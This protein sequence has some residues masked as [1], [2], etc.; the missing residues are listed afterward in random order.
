MYN[1]P[2][3]LRSAREIKTL[4]SHA[5]LIAKHQEED[6][7]VLKLC[8]RAFITWRYWPC[9]TPGSPEPISTLGACLALDVL[10]IGR[11]ALPTPSSIS[12]L[13]VYQASKAETINTQPAITVQPLLP[14]ISAMPAHA[15]GRRKRNR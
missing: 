2:P 11:N 6:S 7:A 9:L 15:E 12:A 10:P 1:A 3:L 4:A 14:V 13:A 5:V 8:S